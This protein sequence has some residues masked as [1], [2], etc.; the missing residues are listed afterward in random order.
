M[1]PTSGVRQVTLNTPEKTEL[2]RTIVRELNEQ[3]FAVRLPSD[4]NTLK[5]CRDG[6]DD[7]WPQ[8]CSGTQN[9]NATCFETTQHG[10]N[11]IC[12][13]EVDCNQGYLRAACEFTLPGSP[14]ITTSKFRQCS[15]A[16]RRLWNRLPRWAWI[17]IIVLGSL[18]LL[19]ILGAVIGFIARAKKGSTPK[20]RSLPEPRP[21]E[22]KV[23]QPQKRRDDP[24]AEPMLIRTKQVDDSGYLQPR[25][26]PID[27]TANA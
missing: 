8:F 18:L 17:L 3:S 11:D 25:S 2:F 26:I 24:A 22:L 12:L 16:P 27:T 20:K 23:I 14:E 6:K 15:I 21:T 5:R 13:R 7:K 4:Y 9:S 1:I 19:G 10:E